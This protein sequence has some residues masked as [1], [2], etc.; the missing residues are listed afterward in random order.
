MHRVDYTCKKTDYIKLSTE[1]LEYN[2]ADGSTC[3]DVDNGD[4]YIFYK[5]VWYNQISKEA[6]PQVMQS[7]RM[8]ARP[9][10]EKKPTIEV[11]EGVEDDESIY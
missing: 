7:M 5:G 1:S 4:W 2:V 9:K 11:I 8:M 6:F 3:Y 10:V